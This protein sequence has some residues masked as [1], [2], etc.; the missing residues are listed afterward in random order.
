MFA[1]MFS[2]HSD[3]GASDAKPIVLEG[4]TSFEFENVLSCL[5]PRYAT[6]LSWFLIID[7]SRCTSRLGKVDDMPFDSWSSVLKFAMKWQFDSIRDIAMEHLQD[8]HMDSPTLAQ[9]IVLAKTHHLDAWYQQACL[10]LCERSSPLTE[11]EAEL[12][13]KSEIVRISAIRHYV[14]AAASDG[15]HDEIRLSEVDICNAEQRMGAGLKPATSGT[16]GSGTRKAEGQRRRHQLG[17]RCGMLTNDMGL[18]AVPANTDE[19][20]SSAT[21]WGSSAAGWGSGTAGWGS[22]TSGWEPSAGGWGH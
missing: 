18:G 6:L 4:T 13:D 7:S 15:W 17:R 12:L 21:G 20:G 8:I 5:Y 9:Q 2:L 16:Q 14:R 10:K 19:W 22:S 11:A 3:E 1:D